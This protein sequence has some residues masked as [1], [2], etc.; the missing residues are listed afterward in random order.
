MRDKYEYRWY[1]YL[2]WPLWVVVYYIFLFIFALLAFT[3]NVASLVT[4]LLPPGEWKVDFHQAVICG[5]S[6]ACF[7][8]FRITGIVRIDCYGFDSISRER[9][10]PKPVL[11]ANHPSLLDVFTFYKKLPRL[12]CIYKSS[13]R[14]TL[15]KAQMGEQIGFISNENAREMIRK[16]AEKVREGRQLLIF[17][18]AT[19]TE[20]ERWPINN[21]KSG[22]VAIAKKAGVPLLPVTIHASSNVLTKS[23][24]IWAIP[25]LPIRYR[26]EV[27]EPFD[28][29]AYERHQDANEALRAHFAER[30]EAGPAA[31][32]E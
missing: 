12:T 5:M 4:A 15:V 1:D 30:L 3:V 11:V 19:R 6:R 8:I 13:L 21:L 9:G 28:P 14:K 32:N 26:L 18:E 23:Q 2:L 10:V 31:S 7:A 22:A 27:G 24:S 16:G 29:A 20:P 25:I 17:P